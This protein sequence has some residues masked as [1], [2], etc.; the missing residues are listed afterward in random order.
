MFQLSG[1]LLIPLCLFVVAVGLIILFSV[2]SS[3]RREALVQGWA[4]AHGCVYL[5][6]NNG[7]ARYLKGPPFTGG[8]GA[9]VREFV[10]GPTPSGL[11]FCSFRYTYEES[12]G[13]DAQGHQETTTV[14]RAIVLVRLPAAFPGLR[15]TRESFL[16][17]VSKFFGGQDIEL[18]S[19]DFNRRYRVTSDNEAFAYGVLHPRMME[20]LLGPASGLVPLVIDGADLLFWREG[21][22]DYSQLDSQL[23]ALDAFIGM[24]P[25]GVYEQFGMAPAPA[26]W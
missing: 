23:A 1:V 2:R 4:A 25:Q 6:T 5:R 8:W 22:P 26:Y 14:N 20:W 16:D 11:V 10:K 13:T 19:D 12:S 24:F 9:E 17:K 18:E 7:L 3:R 21:I 15:L